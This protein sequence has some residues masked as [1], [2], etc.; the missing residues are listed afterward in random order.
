[1]KNRKK[2]AFL[3]L[4]GIL[5]AFVLSAQ[6]LYVTLLPKEADHQ[7]EVRIEGKLFTSFQYPTTQEKPFLY[8]IVSPEGSTITRGFPLQPRQGER[9]D[10]P[11]HVGMWF[12]HGDVNGLDFWNNSYAIK[13]KSNYGH[14]VVTKILKVKSGKKAV[15]KVL[16]EW[17]D[18]ENQPLLEETTSY[19]FSATKQTRTIDHITTLQALD[20][21]VVFSD[22][23]EGMIALRMD[24]AFETPSTQAMT[25]VDA[26]GIPTTV[27]GTPDNTGVNGHYYAS[28]GATG[29]DVW[30][31]HNKWVM[32]S[33]LKNGQL[34]SLGFFD[35]PDNVGYPFHA[36]AR[37]YGL[38]ACNNIGAQVY[39]KKEK[40]ITVTLDP[41]KSIVFKHRF[42]V[43]SGKKVSVKQ[44]NE[45]SKAFAKE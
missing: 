41:H 23:K 20:K 32:L 44:A 10:H 29:D 27:K 17:R 36:H 25:F 35:S 39:N 26:N 28:C 9:V 42:F 19:I 3:S 24:R 6:N 38:F 13:D 33:A 11:H 21:K 5:S 12:N 18:N 4:C 37:G 1:M 34:I 7:V 30:G 22:C 45:I 8:P 43:Q 15:L 31:T 2:K 40:K 16:S 14:I